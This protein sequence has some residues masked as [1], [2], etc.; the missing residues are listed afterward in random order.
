MSKRERPNDFFAEDDDDF[1]FLI[2]SSIANDT[3]KEINMV[4]L[5][6]YLKN[7]KES[8]ISTAQPKK[9]TYDSKAFD[10]L[11]FG[12]NEDF[13]DT[14]KITTS[15]FND[16]DP[17]LDEDRLFNDFDQFNYPASPPLLHESNGYNRE[18][19][20]TNGPSVVDA[21]D[22]M[23]I[24]DHEEETDEVKSHQPRYK[25]RD[26]TVAPEKGAFTTAICPTTGKT[27]F[28]AKKTETE[29]KRKMNDLVKSVISNNSNNTKTFSGR[30][31]TK[32]KN[33][34]LS[35]PLWKLR[36]K[37]ESANKEELKRIEEEIK[38]DKRSKK[39]K[40]LVEFETNQLWVDKYRPASYSDL[41]GDQRVNRDV[42]KWLKQWD[43]CVFKRKP[44]QETERDKQLRQYKN[45]FG[46][47]LKSNAFKKVTKENTDPLLRPEKKILLL[48]GP[49]GFGKTTLSHVLAQ[50]AGYNVIEVNASDDRT[51][52]VVKSKIRS[53]LEM[54]A[55]IRE[56]SSKVD[57]EKIMKMTQKPNLLIIDE[58]DGASSGGGAESFIK[59]LV[60]LATADFDKDKKPQKKGG[61]KKEL[62]PLLRPIICICNDPYTPVLRPLRMV[63]QFVQFKKV[64]M[65]SLAKRLQ[66]ICYNEGLESDLRTL[67]LLSE[68]TN[69]D[70]RSCLNTLQ[71]IRGKST[72]FTKD[73]LD[74]A[75]LGKKDMGITLF[76]VWEDLFN[77]PNARKKNAAN[78]NDFAT[79]KFLDRLLNLIM[80]NGEYDRLMQGCF[81]SY[82]LMRYHDIAFKKVCQL[83]EWL[84]F[85]DQINN[86]TSG[87]FEFDLYKYL[88]FPIVNFHRFFAGTTMQEHRVEY[89]RFEYETFAAKKSYENLIEI[90][91]AGIQ[92]HKRRY[93]SKDMIV[94]ELVPRLLH[95]I[96][97]DLK[98]V[99]QQLIKPAEKAKLTKL[100][101][102]MIE[103]GLNFRQEKTE[104]GQFVY[105]LEPPV[106][107]LLQFELSSPKAI[108]PRQYAVRQMISNEIETEILRRREEAANERNKGKERK[109][110]AQEQISFTEQLKNKINKEKQV[111]LD[112]FGR[113]I[114]PKQ[115]SSSNQQKASTH[116]L[117]MQVDE[118]NTPVAYKFHE[119]FSN[120]VR[121]PM[122]VRM[123]L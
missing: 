122:T 68:I 111:P 25:G 116:Q 106:E 19:Q 36:E 94:N 118:K 119:G 8:T 120:A 81:E 14:S 59:Q 30:H 26:Y 20:S 96:S 101:D 5:D 75:G 47:D 110:P 34:L 31:L 54:Q 32:A 35:E 64:P 66:D 79:N 56:E 121:K 10:D 45:T 50:Q 13:L 44:R 2:E 33:G 18:A 49:P 53:A 23:N 27:L 84:H 55:I 123:F 29:L 109:N 7:H 86:R 1:D 97:P 82:P 11:I 89:P 15:A 24:S 71:F 88:P 107:Q 92:P 38:R 87:Q 58:I 12:D 93:I 73:M 83:T 16:A 40:R 114:V 9:T 91:M 6:D 48:S 80:L 46:T 95:I 43:Y 67:S 113:P 102:K 21:L 42:L 78:K 37:I 85:Y 65:V 57:G 104:E 76:A 108:L 62:K 61:R 41:L 100:V 60:A 98:P 4:G 3:G 69:G 63:A 90:F 115:S 51:G 17:V 72:I 52:E 117:K 39:K 103:F 105:K 99:N 77:A 112:F 28:F 70:I 22:Y 74:K